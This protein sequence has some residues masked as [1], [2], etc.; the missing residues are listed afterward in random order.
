MLV[1]RT[2]VQDNVVDSFT[3][4]IRVGVMFVGGCVCAA[5]ERQLYLRNS[6]AS[7]TTTYPGNVRA[8][9]IGTKRPNNDI[10]AL[11][12]SVDGVRCVCVWVIDFFAAK[13]I[14]PFARCLFMSIYQHYVFKLFKFSMVYP[15]FNINHV[16][17][18]NSLDFYN[19]AELQ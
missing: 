19:N 12:P 17:G 11:L 8:R 4:C 5:H 10:S 3:R 6:G 1:L 18:M 2:R 9:V 15:L 16:Y 7:A 14:D 13:R